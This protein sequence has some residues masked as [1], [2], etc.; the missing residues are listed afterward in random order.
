[1]C[2]HGAGMAGAPYC[3]ARSLNGRPRVGTLLS[4]QGGQRWSP[5]D[6]R[7]CQ[8]FSLVPRVHQVE[9]SRRR[10]REVERI[11]REDSGEVK[12][13]RRGS[14]G[15]ALGKQQVEDLWQ[16]EH[17]IRAASE[18]SEACER[19]TKVEVRPAL[20][21]GLDVCA[22]R[23]GGRLGMRLYERD[24]KK[25]ERLRV[26]IP[27]KSLLPQ[28]VGIGL[29]RPVLGSDSD[30]CGRN[31]ISNAQRRRVKRTHPSSSRDRHPARTE[32]PERDR[33]CLNPT[34]QARRPSSN[35]A[36]SCRVSM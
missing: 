21:R 1:M 31:G 7:R 14:S 9:P 10:E 22:F 16:V 25:G 13:E 8:T 27:L 26:V 4:R 6:R 12:L 30:A 36:S 29:R 20:P 24:C 23:Q 3:P 34:H 32:P 5:S 15:A 35:P 19:T 18:T 28:S 11:L 2:W 33:P 17:P